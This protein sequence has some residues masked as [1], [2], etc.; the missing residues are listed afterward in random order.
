MKPEEVHNLRCEFGRH[1]G[2]LYTRLPVSYL[3]WI[4]NQFPEDD[5]RKEIAEAELKRRGTVFPEIEISGHAIDRVSMDAWDIFLSTRKKK[6]GLHAWLVRYAMEALEGAGKKDRYEKGKLSFRV[7][8][9]NEWPVVKT[10]VRKD[11]DRFVGI[12]G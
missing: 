1:K 12:D 5:R 9:F 8:W 10:V 2:E 4:L 11:K 6:E 3:Q 7:E